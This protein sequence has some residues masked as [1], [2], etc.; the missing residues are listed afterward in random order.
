MKERVRRINRLIRQELSGI[1]FR[2]IIFPE[3]VLVTITRAETSAD[4]SQVKVY[5][6]SIP[7]S[8]KVMPLLNKAAGFIQRCLNKRLN[9]KRTPR[10][11]FLKEKETERAARIEEI[12]DKLKNE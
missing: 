11:K 3:N 6:S 9:I 12:L 2:E 5:V 10:I 4:L 7:A 8:D 1:I